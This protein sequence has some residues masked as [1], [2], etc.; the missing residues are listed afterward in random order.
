MDNIEKNAREKAEELAKKIANVLDS[1][2]AVNIKLLKLTDETILTDY[3]VIANGTSTT[4]VKNLAG[5]VEFKLGEEGIKP[6]HAEGM[7]GNA[8]ILLDY[9]TVIVHVFTKEARD[10]YNLERLWADAE[11]VEFTASEE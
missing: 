5:E 3:F 7:A 1:K 2:K 4:H 10:F 8:W 9:T 6:A 11:A